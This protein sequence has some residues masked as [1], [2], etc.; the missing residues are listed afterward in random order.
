M[1]RRLL[2]FLT[3]G[4]LAALDLSALATALPTIAED[5]RTQE[6]TWIGTSYS[7]SLSNQRGT[8]RRESEMCGTGLNKPERWRRS[9]E[10]DCSVEI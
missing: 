3:L 1:R 9:G 2:D 7:V 10:G 8:V 5:L 4:D 6:F